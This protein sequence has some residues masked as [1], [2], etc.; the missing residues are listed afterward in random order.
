MI[1]SRFAFLEGSIETF[2]EEQ[3]NQNTAK[4][5]K[6]DVAFLTEF[7]QTKGETRIEIAEILPAELN[8]L[9]SE[10][11]LS[12]LAKEKYSGLHTAN[13]SWQTRVGKLKLVCVN[14]LKAVGKLRFYLTPIVCKRVCRLFLCRSHTHQLGFTNTSLPTQVCLVKAALNSLLAH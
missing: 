6:R 7:L 9:L 1:S 11:I 8:E 14:G 13:L 4:K 10:F 2:I 3:E 12:I 5:T